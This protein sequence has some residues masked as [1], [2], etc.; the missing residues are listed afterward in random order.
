MCAVSQHSEVVES[1]HVDFLAVEQAHEM[2]VDS[3]LVST[4]GI[5]SKLLE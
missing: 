1:G 4:N 5:S 2:I 3:F